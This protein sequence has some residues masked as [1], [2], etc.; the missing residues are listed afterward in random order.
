MARKKAKDRDP[1]AQRKGR[2]ISLQVDDKLLDRADALVGKV[3]LPAAMC[4]H[5]G[6]QNRS[7]ILRTALEKGL[8]ALERGPKKRRRS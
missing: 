2:V 7:S 6:R 3:E 8:V 1:N 5:G 4:L